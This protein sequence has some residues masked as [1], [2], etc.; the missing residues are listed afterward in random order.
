[1]RKLGRKVLTL[2]LREVLDASRPAR[3]ASPEPGGR[4]PRAGLH[5][6]H[7]ARGTGITSLLDDLNQAGIGFKDLQTTQ[8]SLEIFSSTW[9]GKNN[10]LPRDLAIY[11]FEMARTGRTLLQSIVARSSRRRCTSWC[12][13]RRSAR[14]SPRSRGSYGAFIVPG[15]AMLMLLTQSVTNASFGITFQVHRHDLRDPVGAGLV[16]RD[17]DRLCRRGRDQVGHP[18][19]IIVATAGLFV[20]L[21]IAH[22]AGCSRSSC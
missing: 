21:R 2:Q 13:A 10:E 3:G 11:V 6:R 20:P 1:M 5:L 19:L 15:L 17:R 18:G 7:A 16:S 8:S 22:P 14:A 9:C 12:S 4:R